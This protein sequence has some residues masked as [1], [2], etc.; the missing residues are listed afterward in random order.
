MIHT[1]RLDKGVVG[2]DV[3]LGCMRDLYETRTPTTVC[4]NPGYSLVDLHHDCNADCIAGVREIDGRR[5]Q[6]LRLCRCLMQ[7][8]HSTLMGA[9]GGQWMPEARVID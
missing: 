7:H 5:G 8:R 1:A 4:L 2:K 9:H 3:N 6:P